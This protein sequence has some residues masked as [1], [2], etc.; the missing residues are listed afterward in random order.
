MHQQD[1][2]AAFKN[3]V[4]KPRLLVFRLSRFT[5]RLQIGLQI[6]DAPRIPIM[7]DAFN[8]NKIY[9]I[10]LNARRQDPALHTKRHR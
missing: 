10:M 9:L 1:L 7:N 3:L 6:G 4:V 8:Y 5:T 2:Q